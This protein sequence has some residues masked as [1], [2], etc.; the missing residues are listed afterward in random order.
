[1]FEDKALLWKLKGGEREGFVG[2]YEKYKERLLTI[3][4]CLLGEGRIAEEIVG[5]VF[6]RFAREAGGVQL[7]GSLS[8]YLIGRVLGMV[9]ERLGSEMYEVVGLESTGP[10]RAEA[11]EKKEAVM[12]DEGDER[13]VEELG[14]LVENQRE[15]VVLHLLGGMGLKD[16]ARLQDVSVS[17]AQSRYRYGIDKLET[18]LAIEWGAEARIR[19][20]RRGMPKEV[21]ERVL[22][23]ASSVLVEAGEGKVGRSVWGMAGRLAAAVAVIVLVLI[24]VIVFTG[25]GQEGAEIAEV[26]EVT[27]E[28]AE[29]EEEKAEERFEAESRRIM[30][31]GRARD[32]EGL[33]AVLE[34]GAAE[35]KILAAYYLGQFG[36]VRSAEGLERLSGEIGGGEEDNPF[37]AAA[38]QI[39]ERAAEAAARPVVVGVRIVDKETGEGVRGYKFRIISKSAGGGEVTSGETDDYG[40]GEVELAGGDYAVAAESWEGGEYREVSQGVS[41][42]AVKKDLRVEVGVSL[43]PM[44]YGWLLDSAG[45]GV[46]GYFDFGGEKVKSDEAGEFELAEPED[47]GVYVCWGFD[48]QGRRGRGL[49]WSK[50]KG[51]KELE[52]VV[53]EFTGIVGR[54]VDAN[55]VGVTEAEVELGV[56]VGEG[57]RAVIEPVWKAVME[58]EGWFRIDGVPV[59]LE[60]AIY[61][62]GA[63]A[64]DFVKVGGLEAGATVDAGDIVVGEEML[65]KL[66]GVEKEIEWDARLGGVVT[67]DNGE[68]LEGVFVSVSYGERDFNDV[69]DYEGRYE[70]TGLPRGEG[71]ELR[72]E[73]E[74]YSG[75]FNVICDGSDF[76]FVLLPEGE[77]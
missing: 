65:A 66:R 45:E 19:G 73:L 63:E 72:A 61:L 49:L 53:E 18:V 52:V 75:T 12:G 37:A 6:I 3:A 40:F 54:V 36:D 77:E 7:Y 44:I 30:A 5:E 76:D 17:T 13:V 50:G 48:E 60:M 43:R 67:D 56:V 25:P 21:D 41:V 23:E 62:A 29:A 14:E 58:E 31:M 24:V 71:V 8:E 38:R 47:E 34:E 35:G 9:R 51:E 11:G 42:A 33:S 70:L 55:G 1:M 4:V 22:A 59:G 27:F 64:N 57:Q 26:E 46:G 10:I 68:V 69:T 16:I 74:G 39:R 2:I 20:L 28:G 32:V 15:A